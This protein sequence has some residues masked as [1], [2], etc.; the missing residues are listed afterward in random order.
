MF[1]RTGVSRHLLLSEVV[2]FLLHPFVLPR[3]VGGFYD[4]RAEDV[5]ASHGRS[6]ETTERARTAGD[7]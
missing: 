6:G 4:L 2:L 7:C 1:A 5:A 3:H